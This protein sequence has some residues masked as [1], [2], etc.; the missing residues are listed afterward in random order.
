MPF[1]A[2]AEDLR[3][4][5]EFEHKRRHSLVDLTKVLVSALRQ[6]RSYFR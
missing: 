4:V 3:Y 6:T 2:S 1:V 5:A